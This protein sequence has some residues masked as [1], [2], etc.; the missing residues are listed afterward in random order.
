M[1]ISNSLKAIFLLH[2]DKHIFFIG[3]LITDYKHMNKNRSY[4]ILKNLLILICISFLLY[5]I[6]K[7]YNY[8]ELKFRNNTDIILLIIFSKIIYHNLLSLRNYSIYKICANYRGKFIDWG[9]IFFESL[10]LNFLAS[11]AGSVYR[12][13]E[14]KKRGLEYKKY[15]G[16]FYILFTS[17][18][19]INVFLVMM[20]LIFIQEIGFQ[21]K[22]NLLLIFLILFTLIGYS[23]KILQ[24]F[25]KYNFFKKNIY[26]YKFLKKIFDVYEYIFSFIKSQIFLKKTIIYLIGYGVVIHLIEL[27]IFYITSIIIQPEIAIK[28]ILILFALNFILDR[29]PLISSIPGINELLF[30]SISIPLGLFFFEGLVLRLVIRVTDITSIFV[31]YLIFYFSNFKNKVKF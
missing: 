11:H 31:N 2:S 6:F 17:Y 12:A 9:Q 13:I 21:F 19:L 29:I 18:I 26:K 16:M 25:I 15:T 3:G 7:N 20:E 8:I 14:T 23:P 24:L 22:M 27:Y 28:T 4:L 10:I 30:A 5:E 1:N